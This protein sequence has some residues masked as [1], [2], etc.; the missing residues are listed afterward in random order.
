LFSITRTR[1]SVRAPVSPTAQRRLSAIQSSVVGNRSFKTFRIV[2][3][4]TAIPS[5]RFASRVR[6]L[7]K[8]SGFGSSRVR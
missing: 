1:P 3:S 2:A 5:A 8:T 4:S 7:R 6:S